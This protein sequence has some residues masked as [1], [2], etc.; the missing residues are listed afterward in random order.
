MDSL[1]PE[2]SVST[3]VDGSSLDGT[4]SVSLDLEVSDGV[5]ELLVPGTGV[6]PPPQ[7]ARS[8][9]LARTNIA[10]LNFGFI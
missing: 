4:V 8:I 2:S 1:L 9:A 7:E 6:L 5:V 10:L 3:G